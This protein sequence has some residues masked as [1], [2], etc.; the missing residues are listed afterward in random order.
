MCVCTYIYIYILW[1]VNLFFE[2]T[3]ALK[4]Y[5]NAAEAQDFLELLALQLLVKPG[6]VFVTC[7]PEFDLIQGAIVFLSFH[8]CSGLRFYNGVGFKIIFLRSREEALTQSACSMA[9]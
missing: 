9:C 1:I 5:A 3:G 8:A 4:G 6:K 2:E 7:I